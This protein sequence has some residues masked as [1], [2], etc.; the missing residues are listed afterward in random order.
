M[1]GRE[2]SATATTPPDLVQSVDRAIR[3]LETLGEKGGFV[4]LQRLSQETA[5]NASTAHRLLHTLQ[6]HGLAR[7][8]STTRKYALG[9]G[10]LRLAS[11]LRD[12]LDLRAE[13]RPFLE[14]LAEETG[15]SANLVVAD[16]HHVVYVDQAASTQPVR[17][18]TQVGAQAPLHCT[19]VGKALLAFLPEVEREAVLA[20]NL[21]A[22]TPETITNPLRLKDELGRIRKR[23]VALD[24]GERQQDVRCIASPVFDDRSRVVAAISISGPRHRLDAQRIEE[25]SPLV[26]RAGRDLSTTLGWAG[27][28][29]E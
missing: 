29:T 5:L 3:L 14:S 6:W 19:G 11:A 28:E 22:Y 4:S 18:F 24:V 9:L 7:R 12:Q 17:A 23:R 16:G 26:G 25:L 8:D 1:H 21:H 20:G 13:A 27:P 10:L 15:E 2:A